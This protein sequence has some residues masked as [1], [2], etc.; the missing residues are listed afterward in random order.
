MKTGMYVEI[1]GK[2]SGRIEAVEQNTLLIRKAKTTFRNNERLVILTSEA[3]YVDRKLI[4]AAYWIKLLDE[5]LV[6]ES[7]DLVNR[8]S[9]ISELLNM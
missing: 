6:S 2:V 8:S 3:V 5:E 9:L 1:A 7:I 4:E